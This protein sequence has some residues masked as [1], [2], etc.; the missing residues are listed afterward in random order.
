MQF[1]V[2]NPKKIKKKLWNFDKITK[3][4]S[5]MKKIAVKHDNRDRII[6]VTVPGKHE[7][8]YQ[9]ANTKERIWLFDTKEFYGSVFAYFR[10]KGRNLYGRGYSLTLKEIYAFRDFSNWRVTKVIE[11]IPRQVEYVLV[12]NICKAKEITDMSYSDR[13][14]DCLHSDIY[15]ERIA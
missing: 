13:T 1:W 8:Y 4:M 10:D 14:I 7:F 15:D 6:C 5:A 11:N 3:E 2:C 12:N 9:A